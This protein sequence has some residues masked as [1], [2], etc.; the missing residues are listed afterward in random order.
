MAFRFPWESLKGD[1]AAGDGDGGCGRRCCKQA[2]HVSCASWPKTSPLATAL[3][4]TDDG[5]QD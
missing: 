1:L 3:A 2:G 4:K 5:A